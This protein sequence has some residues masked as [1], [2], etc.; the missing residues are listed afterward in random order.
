MLEKEFDLM[1]LILEHRLSH[2]Y[3]SNLGHD[4]DFMKKINVENSD[5]DEEV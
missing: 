2:A 1:D 3:V 5:S 4:F